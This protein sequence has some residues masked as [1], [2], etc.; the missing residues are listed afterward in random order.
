MQVAIDIQVESLVWKLGASI[1]PGAK[2]QQ[3]LDAMHPILIRAVEPQIHRKN[4]TDPE[5]WDSI[6]EMA[7]LHDD[8]LY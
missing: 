2:V 5:K 7:E 3:L 1:G 6:I 4:R 8:I